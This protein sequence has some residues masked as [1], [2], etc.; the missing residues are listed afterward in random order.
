ML[1]MLKKVER[2]LLHVCLVAVFLIVACLSAAGCGGGPGANV[3]AFLNQLSDGNQQTASSLCYDKY[4]FQ[5]MREALDEDARSASVRITSVN[6]EG[7]KKLRRQGYQLKT[8]ATVEE[9]LAGPKADV[10]ARYK[11][12][13]DAARSDLDDAS[14]ELAAAKA[15]LDYSRVTYGPNMPQY[16]AE[17]RRIA[18][19]QPRV[20]RAQ[21]KLDTLNAQKQAELQALQ[22]VAEQ[23]YGSEKAARDKALAANSVSLPATMVGVELANGKSVERRDFVL[24][25]YG[26]AWKLY[27]QKAK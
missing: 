22:S 9:R 3:S 6:E 26:G 19:I 5:E 16:Y 24:A 11:P 7:R 12:L 18:A 15:Q 27:S 10:E 8:V 20:S 17:Q 2:K 21:S 14:R 1:V 4:S 25:W 23:Q 13:L